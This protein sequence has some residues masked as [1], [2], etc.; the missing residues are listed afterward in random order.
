M[1]QLEERASTIYLAEFVSA[2]KLKVYD[3]DENSTLRLALD[4]MR[5]FA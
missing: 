5:R 4:I 1:R 2:E 3:F